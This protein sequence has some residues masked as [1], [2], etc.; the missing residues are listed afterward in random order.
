MT[1][2]S[3]RD[4]MTKDP[5]ACDVTTPVADAARMMRDRDIGDV[6]VCDGD[7]LL[8][9]VTD[10]DLVVRCLAAGAEVA[11]ATV[12][13]VC[14]GGIATISA[15]A[16]IDD[17]AHQMRE[18]AV[19][20]LPVVDGG[21]AVGIVSLGDLAVTGDPSSALADISAAEPQS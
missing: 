5:V 16:S 7:R 13:D 2:A 1:A 9:I 19:R 8:G 11:R 12:G 4:V 14:S 15:D 21:I 20:R 10:R 6:L 3:V 17:A 18:A